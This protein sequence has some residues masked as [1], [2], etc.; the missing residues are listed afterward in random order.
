MALQRVVA[1]PKPT[2]NGTVTLSEWQ[3][4]KRGDKVRVRGVRGERTFHGHVTTQAGNTWVNVYRG[5]FETA[6]PE[7][8]S[9]L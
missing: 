8:V 2:P 1:A 7:D 5:Q 6:N 9:A 3:G 4:I